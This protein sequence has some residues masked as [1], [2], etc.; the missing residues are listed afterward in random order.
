MCVLARI[1]ALNGILILFSFG[2]LLLIIIVFTIFSCIFP[3]TSVRRA[4][5]SVRR[6]LDNIKRAL[7]KKIRLLF[8]GIFKTII[9]NMDDTCAICLENYDENNNNNNIKWIEL[10]CGHKFHKICIDK[11][12]DNSENCPECRQSIFEGKNFK[13]ENDIKNNV[14]NGLSENREQQETL[15]D[16][17]LLNF[18]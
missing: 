16:T 14:T 6:A 13:K 18:V 3:S 8:G 12:V 2:I 15:A 1:Y 7:L 4:S 11:V 5:T 17:T 9:P 10:K